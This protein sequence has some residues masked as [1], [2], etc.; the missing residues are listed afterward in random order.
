VDVKTNWMSGGWKA[1]F[2]VAETWKNRADRYLIIDSGWEK[3][4]GFLFEPGG[5]YLVYANRKYNSYKT[6]K[7]AGTKRVSDAS[8]DLILL[9]P[10][11]AP[12]S[13][14]VSGRLTVILLIA[15]FASLGL[16]GFIVLR[17]KFRKNRD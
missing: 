14:G 13:S 8:S 3:D 16:V 17:K 9:G 5:E 12:A 2:R 7:C 11:A 1:T 4:C 6:G 10:G 15:A